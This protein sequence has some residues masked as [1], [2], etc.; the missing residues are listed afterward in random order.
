M[1][2]SLYRVF[3]S[4]AAATGRL[5]GGRLVCDKVAVLRDAV[6]ETSCMTNSVTDCAT[7]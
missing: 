7:K 2:L 4:I 6:K 1:M 3:L 5:G